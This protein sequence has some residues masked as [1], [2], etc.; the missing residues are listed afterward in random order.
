MDL[1]DIRPSGHDPGDAVGE[2][3]T[4]GHAMRGVM[5]TFEDHWWRDNYGE[6]EELE[7]DR[8]YDYY[9]PAFRYGWEASDRHRGKGWG[10]VESDLEREWQTRHGGSGAKWAEA[11][12]AIRHAF[13]RA[14]D[15]FN[16]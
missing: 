10:E 6:L 14:Q 7:H 15:T 13:E 16:R 3:I 4:S 12:R 9:R 5:A 8:G 1:S 11:K 2:S